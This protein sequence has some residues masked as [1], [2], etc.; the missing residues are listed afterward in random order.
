MAYSTA[1]LLV[2]AGMKRGAS[3]FQYNALVACFIANEQDVWCGTKS[4]YLGDVVGTE[5]TDH[6]AYVVRTHAYDDHL[7]DIAT[8]VFT[9]YRQPRPTYESLCRFMDVS[10]DWHF[11]RKLVEMV[12]Q[13]REEADHLM[14]YRN[15]VRRGGALAEIKAHIG[16]LRIAPDPKGVTMLTANRMKPPK[17]RNRDRDSL[18]WRGHYTSMDYTDTLPQYKDPTHSHDDQQ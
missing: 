18:V 7:A 15:L 3:A 1:P 11:V 12:E 2:A 5:E 4:D 9:S 16:S 14:M 8:H 17:V 10:P 13:W 6:D